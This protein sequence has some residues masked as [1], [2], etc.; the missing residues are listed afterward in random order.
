[1][2]VNV[3]N[4]WDLFVQLFAMTMGVVVPLALLALLTVLV[5]WILDR[6]EK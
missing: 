6:R 4:C 5:L 2:E 3:K 1:M